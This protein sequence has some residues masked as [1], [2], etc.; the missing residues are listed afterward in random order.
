LLHHYVHQRGHENAITFW[1]GCGAVK[2]DVFFEM[3]GFDAKSYP[4][5]S[6]EDIELGYRLRNSGYQI[7]LNKD[8]QVTHL[9]K[10]SLGGLLRSDIIDRALRWTQLISK[11]K[12][13]PNDLNLQISQRVS[14]IL[15]L[16][17]VLYLGLFAFQ[18]NVYLLPLLVALFLLL[19]GNRNWYEDKNVFHRNLRGEKRIFLLISTIIILALLNGQTSLLAPL[20]PLLFILLIERYTPE[21]DNLFKRILF[22]GAMVFISADFIILLI[23]FP[24]EIIGPPLVTLAVV[25]LLNQHL[26]R[27]FLRK[28]GLL[29]TLAVIPFH[30]LYYLYSFLTFIIGGGLYY[31]NTNLRARVS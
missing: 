3:G 10:W 23:S 8:I 25:L 26:Y 15:L 27:F 21:K 16:F 17:V 31:W 9:K 6:I 2:R 13:L 12:N 30:L 4:K 18:Y 20:V 5:P 14:A 7:M 1:S 22:V 19:V 24:L 29:F 11:Y 28:R